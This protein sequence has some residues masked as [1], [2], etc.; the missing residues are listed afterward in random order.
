MGRI[1]IGVA[2]G[3]LAVGTVW[4]AAVGI[5]D[6]PPAAG[7]GEPPAIEETSVEERARDPVCGMVTDVDGHPS[8]VYRNTRFHFCS[9]A[10]LDRFRADPASFTTG[11]PG[12]PCVCTV[13]EM[14]DCHCGHC[15]GNPERCRCGDP[16]P[17]GGGG[18]DDHDHGGHR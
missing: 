9:Q 17:A 8:H 1:G 15:T 7:G 3:V 2:A 10:C 4:W 6:E 13:G 16:R 14:E 18:H 5:G 12:E 11:L